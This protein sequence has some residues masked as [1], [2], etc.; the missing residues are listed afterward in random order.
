MEIKN[1]AQRGHTVDTQSIGR[2]RYNGLV[3]LG[4]FFRFAREW[5]N[6]HK[7]LFVERSA[8]H[9]YGSG[10]L[11]K[12]YEWV[13]DKKV[14]DYLRYDLLIRFRIKD[15]I[16]VEVIREGE[17][18]KLQQCRMAIEF[19]GK[20]TYDPFGRFGK[21]LFGQNL[22]A[23]Y[24]RFYSKQDIINKW[25]DQFEQQIKDL[26]KELEKFLQFESTLAL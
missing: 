4:E 20:L 22:Q 11:D 19:E 9:K 8:K 7:Y 10:G 13:A 18:Q 1:P 15:I 23:I 25:E 24:H 12:E 5:F 17:K 14:Y 2:I 6:T 26:Q 16:D 21:G 3:D